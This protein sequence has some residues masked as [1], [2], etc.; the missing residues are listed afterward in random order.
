LA[1]GSR[2]V[3]A[4]GEETDFRFLQYPV[5]NMALLQSEPLRD[6]IAELDYAG[7]STAELRLAPTAPRFRF[8]SP[9][10]S[11][12]RICRD[13][14]SRR[15]GSNALGRGQVVGEDD[16][17]DLAAGPGDSD[18]DL[19]DLDDDDDDAGNVANGGGALCTVALPDPEDRTCSVFSEFRSSRV[20]VS[21]Y[22]LEL[23][24]RC[25]K[26]LALSQTCKV[27][28]N[29]QG[30]LSLVCRMRPGMATSSSAGERRASM[31]AGE[32][33]FTEFIIVAE[34]IDS[35]DDDDDDDGED[36]DHDE[37]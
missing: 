1:V 21:C 23:L 15:Q 29:A 10:S 8:R 27:Q 35:Y 18:D 13:R 16:D 17:D 7:A 34:E 36:A 5:H 25:S 33:L 14:G 11:F 2:Q 6:A 31:S 12:V 30:M 37:S 4:A 3:V 22:R 19:D 32:H 20:Q 9:A 26:A 28:M 24:Q